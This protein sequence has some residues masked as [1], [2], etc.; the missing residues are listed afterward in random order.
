MDEALQSVKVSVVIPTRNRYLQLRAA[1]NSVLTQ[2][3]Q[4][5]EIIIVDDASTIP[6]HQR[7]DILQDERIRI[8]RNDQAL[9]GSASRN[10]GIF[11]S[12]GEWLAFLDDDDLW[13]P[14]KLEQQL[15]LL[16]R[17]PK[18][19]ACSSAY[20]VH[21]PGAIKRKIFTPSSVTLAKLMEQNCLGGSSVLMAKAEILKQLNGFNAKLRSA[22]DWDLWVRLRMHGEIISVHTVGVDYFVHFNERISNNMQ[23]KYQGARH[24]YFSYRSLM[25]NPTKQKHLQ[26]I[27]FIKSRMKQNSLRLRLKN[28]RK[29]IK[30]SSKKQAFVYILSS[31]PRMF[32]NRL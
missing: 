25:I 5:F 28:L 29:A 13:R 20:M 11:Q 23:S 6:I 18:A 15:K 32:F 3:F 12:K 14:Q 7:E 26:F 8:L 9:G 27:C 1:L 17:H 21:Y 4:D 10:R 30:N 24:F 2:T 19:I 31:L 16:L 22:Q